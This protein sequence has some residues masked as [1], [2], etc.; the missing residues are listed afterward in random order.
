MPDMSVDDYTDQFLSL[1]CRDADLSDHQLVQIYTTDLVKRLKTGV[2][3]RRPLT[4]DDAIMLAHA[5][6]QLLQLHQTDPSQ[7]RSARPLHQ[8]AAPAATLKPSSA[9]Q[10]SAYAA[11]GSAKTTAVASTLLRFRLTQVVMA[12][13]RADGLCYNCDKKFV[14]GHP[15]KKMFELEIV[16][17]DDEAL[18][19]E[20]DCAALNLSMDARAS[21]CAPSQGCTHVA[22]K[23]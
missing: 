15:C 11:S 5:Y 22:T 23:P 6:E 8:S 7:G 20:I 4:L 10:S 2:A 13:C 18:D 3:L 12:Q 9:A 17:S 14:V 16:D 1:A 21:P 19:E